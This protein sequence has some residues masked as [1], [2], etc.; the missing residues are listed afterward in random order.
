M[1]VVQGEGTDIDLS[2]KSRRYVSTNHLATDSDSQVLLRVSG[3]RAT[4]TSGFHSQSMLC[5]V[6]REELNDATPEYI[7]HDHARNSDQQPRGCGLER[8]AQADHD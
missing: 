3:W 5:L 8:E 1:T 4:R 6:L 2:T 7:V